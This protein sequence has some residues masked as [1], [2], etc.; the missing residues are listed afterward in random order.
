MKKAALILMLAIGSISISAQTRVE[1]IMAELRD[2]NSKYVAVIAHRGDW[3]NWPECSLPAIESAIRMGADA[4]ELDVRK[5]A[6]G[7]LVICHDA[8]I[9]RTTSGKGKIEELSLDS[10]RKCCL[11]A[12]NNI[13][14]RTCRMPTLEE[15]L[16]VCK[17]RC[18][19]NLDRGYAY[20]DQIMEMVAAR[21]MQD[22]VIVNTKKHAK[23]VARK[24][25]TYDRNMLHAP[26]IL[27]NS[28]KWDAYRGH[29]DEYISN[30]GPHFAYEV[31]WNGT[32]DG[33]EEIFRRVTESG[34]I[35]WL[36]T[37][38]PSMCG[39]YD[40]GLE[41][42]RAIDNEEAIYGKIVGYGARI[43]MTE[44][45]ALLVPYLER[46]GHHTLR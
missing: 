35:L 45:P 7:H 20:Y 6:D 8:T 33:V 38:F 34:A 40:N 46:T 25:A 13:R 4:V 19:V 2:P 17:D 12:G 44:R 37:I 28:D 39:G 42:D 9:D 27:Y 23:Y 24:Y 21:G 26:I 16:D 18:I 3:R 30:E 22:Q 14:K 29:L 32:L 31:C 43:I 5:T 1:R 15:A 36:N 10:I 41:D 11:R